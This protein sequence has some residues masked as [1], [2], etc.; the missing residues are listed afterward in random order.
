MSRP[1]LLG[2]RDTLRVFLE[3]LITG[4]ANLYRLDYELLRTPD[5]LSMQRY[6]TAFYYIDLHGTMP[7]LGVAKKRI[8]RLSG[9]Q[10]QD[11]HALR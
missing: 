11:H 5:P 7:L 1:V 2:T 6:I 8:Q 10:R 9:R 3:H 4:G